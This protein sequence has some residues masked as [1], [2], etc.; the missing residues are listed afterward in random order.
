MATRNLYADTA[1]GCSYPDYISLN[2]VDGAVVLT[3]RGPARNPLESRGFLDCGETV[4]LELTHARQ[5]GLHHAL[6]L[7]L[8]IG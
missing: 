5:V 2:D 1:P 8:G 6:G 7:L 3:L 4:A